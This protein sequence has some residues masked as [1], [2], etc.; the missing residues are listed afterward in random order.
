MAGR[1]HHKRDDDAAL[2]ASDPAPDPGDDDGLGIAP[3]PLDDMSIPAPEDAP[4]APVEGPGEDQAPNPGE[5]DGDELHDP[6]DGVLTSQG[7]SSPAIG[8]RVVFVDRQRRTLTFS[9]MVD[10]IRTA[11]SLAADG[12]EL[13][14]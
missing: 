8:V 11:R 4:S 1:P 6:L 7:V 14:E 12:V 3:Q 13:Y 2:D 5:D 9:S 10:F